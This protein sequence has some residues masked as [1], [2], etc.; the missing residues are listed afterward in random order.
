MSRSLEYEMNA[1]TYCL[2]L[3]GRHHVVASTVL[4]MLGK[5]EAGEWTSHSMSK[6]KRM[7]ESAR[8]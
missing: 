1:A 5:V 3:S 8:V 4:K 6:R 7:M 2:W